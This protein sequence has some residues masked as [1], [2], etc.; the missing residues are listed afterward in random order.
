MAFGRLRGVRLP[1]RGTAYQGV[2]SP[3]AVQMVQMFTDS[4]GHTVFDA[5][6]C[7][8]PTLDFPLALVQMLHIL[9]SN[10]AVLSNHSH[11]LRPAICHSSKR[12]K[13]RI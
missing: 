13:S 9:V 4:L 11:L 3:I 6:W 10:F 7:L 8:V 5:N 12:V 1:P 2:R